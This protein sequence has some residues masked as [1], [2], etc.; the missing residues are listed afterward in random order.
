MLTAEQ[1]VELCEALEGVRVRYWLIGGWGV[2]AL[3]GRETRSH[4]DLDI[5]ALIDDLRQLRQMFEDKGF[6][7][8]HVWEESRWTETAGERWPTAF[9]AVDAIGRQID[10]HLI[11]IPSDGL[12]L[13]HYDNPWSLPGRFATTGTIGAKAVP[14]VSRTAQLKMH[15]G[16]VV[17]EEQ[18]LDLE[19]L[20]G[21]QG[22][23]EDIGPATPRARSVNR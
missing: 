14:C 8:S 22:P 21:N 1:A 5:L 3:L 9:V 23:K 2:D 18:Q 10:V 20:R 4:K 13:Q 11:Q 17:P 15:I 6:A 16:Y 19:R 12:I 7:L